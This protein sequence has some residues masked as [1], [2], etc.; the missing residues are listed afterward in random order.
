MSE[1]KVM[2][3]HERIQAEHTKNVKEFFGDKRPGMKE[4]ET[5]QMNDIDQI[6]MV[7]QAIMDKVSS[8]DL[9][10][11]QPQTKIHESTSQEVRDAKQDVV[12]AGKEFGL[13]YDAQTDALISITE[14]KE[15]A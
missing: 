6:K 5:P 8:I 11:R 9:Y 13:T 2:T 15:N 1:V 3:I 4:L 7:L 14:T 10:I 12:E